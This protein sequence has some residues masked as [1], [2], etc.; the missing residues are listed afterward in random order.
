MRKWVVVVVFAAVATLVG[1]SGALAKGQHK[2]PKEHQLVEWTIP[3]G[4]CGDLPA[5]LSLDGV[6]TSKI[7]DKIKTRRNGVMHE[8]FRETVRGTA[9]DNW[10]NHYRFNYVQTF[11]GSSP[12]TGRLEDHFDLSGDGP[13]NLLSEFAVNFTF[14]DDWAVISEEFIL[15][16]GD[17]FNCDPI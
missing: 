10:G 6:G 12:G 17:P 15:I 5:G 13:A 16:A 8:N 11:K 7:K 2:G 3:A 1:S 14:G 4:Q 9:T